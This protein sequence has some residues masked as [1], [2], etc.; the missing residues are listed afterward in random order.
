[1]YG[2]RSESFFR[3]LRTCFKSYCA[4][5]LRRCA[6]LGILMY[7]STFRFLRSVRLALRPARY[8]LKHVR[9]RELQVVRSWKLNACAEFR[10]IENDGL[11]P[12]LSPHWRIIVLGITLKPIQF[13]H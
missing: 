3:C 5:E 13:L 12:R 4:S 9:N 6:V 8:T 11:P 1:M 7:S 2:S 10:H